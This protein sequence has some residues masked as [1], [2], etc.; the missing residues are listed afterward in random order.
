MHKR[1]L[2]SM[3]IALIEF[4]TIGDVKIG[5]NEV[6]MR[7]IPKGIMHGQLTFGQKCINQFSQCQ[8]VFFVSDRPSRHHS[9]DYQ[10]QQDELQTESKK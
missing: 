6:I 7:H 8:R 9:N 2:V 3:I 10:L 1:I 4:A 5:T